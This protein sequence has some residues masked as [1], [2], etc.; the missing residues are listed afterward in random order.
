MFWIAVALGALRVARRCELLDVFYRRR[1]V[2]EKKK[3]EQQETST[4]ARSQ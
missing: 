4:T 2:E 1:K 3:T